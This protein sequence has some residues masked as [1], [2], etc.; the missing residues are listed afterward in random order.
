MTTYCYEISRETI[1]SRLP[2]LF[3]YVSYN[4]SGEAELHKATDSIDGCYGKII[5][6]IKLPSSAACSFMIGDNNEVTLKG[7]TEYTYRTLIDYYYAYK[8]SDS[9]EENAFTEF[10][11]RGIGKEIVPEDRFPKD[12]YDL[13]PD[14]IYIATAKGLYQKMYKLKILCDAYQAGLENDMEES[15][16]LCC[17]CDEY[18]RMGGEDMIAYLQELIVKAETVANEFLGYAQGIEL[19]VRFNFSL[20]S[21]N[22]D[23]GLLTPYVDYWEGGVEYKVGDF[24]LYNERSYICTRQNKGY[25]D[26]E[27]E[28]ILFPTD[29]FTLISDLGKDKNIPSDIEE[30]EN[31]Y[32]T[33]FDLNRG[34]DVDNTEN[35]VI[36]GTVDSKLKSL[37]RSKAYT[38]GIGNVSFPNP[39]KDWLYYYRVNNVI[40]YE[41]LNTDLG[42]I[43][44]IMDEG[45][46]YDYNTK[47][48]DKYVEGKFNGNG[49]CKEL[50]AYGNLI[51]NITLPQTIKKGE[52]NYLTFEYYLGAHLKAKFPRSMNE[53]AKYDDDGRM[54]YHFSEFERDEDD[55]YHGVKYTDQYTFEWDSDIVKDFYQGDENATEK[56]LNQ[57][58][59]NEYINGEDTLNNKQY[60]FSLRNT[61]NVDERQINNETAI[62]SYTRSTFEATIKNEVD[63][64]Y[65]R[66]FR[67]EYYN[68][69][70]YS[71]TKKSDVFIDRGNAAAMEKC[72]ALGEIRTLDDLLLYKNGSF[73][74]IESIEG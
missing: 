10:I 62:I 43:A 59:F 53:F 58:K 12:K 70:T 72:I 73:F 5:Q 74:R 16:R 69:I 29:C 19:K 14:S 30:T 68:G 67:D 33:K 36:S 48:Y 37:R 24:V 64:E 18:E 52:E 66:V 41:T 71:P 1:I 15:T 55:L 6:S 56:T 11:E 21:T 61:R 22:N 39:D 46:D 57:A 4:A 2:S 3:A 7:D 44:F 8:K 27:T 51:T 20:T 13:A 40:D 34:G 54:L 45:L 42:N 35:Y 49:D 31:P 9:F 63:Y 38:D 23:L 50:Y 65:N 25:W 32:G 60:E 17:S 47:D 28:R 26:E